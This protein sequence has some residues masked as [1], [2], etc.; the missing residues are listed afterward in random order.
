VFR[1]RSPQIHLSAT[2]S[3]IGDDPSY[4]SQASLTG[5]AAILTFGLWASKVSDVH[6]DPSGMG[7]FTS[8]TL[9]GKNH[10]KVTCISAYI[11]IQKGGHVGAD[12]VHAQQKTIYEKSCLASKCPIQPNFC[13]RK[14]AIIT[15]QAYIESLQKQDH[16][17]ILIVDANQAS[18]ECY[19]STDVRPYTI[20]WLKIQCNL[21][22]P[23]I[24]LVGKRPSSTTQIPNRDIDY[25]LTW[26]ISPSH[27]S[28][29]E[30]NTPALSDHLGLILDFDLGSYFNASYLAP[31][32]LP[33]RSLTSG[34]KKAVDLYFW[35]MYWIDSES[36]K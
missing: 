14:H 18:H 12:T 23:F 11:S 35:S 20:E 13:P 9:L 15:L 21:S 8:T 33:I 7:I 27:I 19:S 24:D 30:L 5:E 25:I 16:A 2:S 31:A 29:L 32:P 28:T 4:L 10:K 17:I 3:E 6:Y 22:D 26:N 1:P 34:N 36:T